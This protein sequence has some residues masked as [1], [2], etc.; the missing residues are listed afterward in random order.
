[1]RSLVRPILAAAALSAAL[2]AQ[3]APSSAAAFPV[4]ARIEEQIKPNFG[5][6]L[7]P[8]VYRHHVRQGVWYGRHQGWGRGYVERYGR[9]YGERYERLPFPPGAPSVT[10]DCG[11]PNFG[12]NPISDAAAYVPDYG[13]VY[14][15]G[16]GQACRE[17]IEI[18]HP[19]VIAAEDASAF[20]TDRGRARV[21]IAPPPG[22]P[23]VLIAQGVKQVEIRGF[24]LTAAQG[25]DASCVQAWD[26]EVGLVHDDIDYSGDAS[27]VYIARG[28]LILKQSR[29][30]AHTYDAAV[31][32]EGADLDMYQDRIKAD[33]IGLAV[34]LGPA[35][36]RIERVGVLTTRSAGEASVG[37]E[38]R[39]E[40]SGGALLKIRDAVVCGYRVGVGL[41]RGGRADI[42]RSRICDSSYGIMSEGA[43][44][45][46]TESAIGA[47]RRGV[48]VASGDAKVSHNRIY[49]I[50]DADDGV[51]AERPAGLVDDTNWLYLRRGCERFRWDGRRFCRRDD[52]LPFFLR[53]ESA[54]D[55]DYTDAWDVDGYEDGYMRDGPVLA[56]TPDPPRK[57][58]LFGCS[59][60]RRGGGGGGR[61]GFGGGGGGAGGPP[62][63][64]GGGGGFGGGAPGGGGGFG[65]GPP[66]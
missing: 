25:G 6:L 35:E 44:L 47:D 16:H 65:G 33:T 7:N 61:G 56:F 62:R 20:T 64:G 46:I 22:Q 48:Y 57:C 50:N 27:A 60:P 1:M 38:V 41:E 36:S 5:I 29:I 14:V 8:P 2:I 39:G 55:R 31:T 51:Y 58:G 13:V 4:D 12:P 45:E 30:D 9:P 53:D 11:D 49:G 54:F 32:S 19:V 10:V 40:R 24:Q 34:T 63:G 66:R 52:E 43:N 17:T 23:C 42:R 21:V 37:I 18:D 28:R 3:L 59:Q 15:R 26:T